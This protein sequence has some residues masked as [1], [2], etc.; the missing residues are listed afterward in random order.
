MGVVHH[1][2]Y[3]VWFEMGRTELLREQGSSYRELEEQK[4]FLAVTDLQIKYKASA[5]YDDALSLVTSLDE[6]TN[7]R[8]KH[9]YTLLRNEQVIASAS[10]TIVCVDDAG[11]VQRV[12][13]AITS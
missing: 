11:N 7:I 9:T 12:P 8:V 3:P 13:G 2:V 4:L 6:V 1:A 10:T 5:K